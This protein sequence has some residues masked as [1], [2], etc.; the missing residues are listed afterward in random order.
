PAALRHPAGPALTA[1]NG[2]HGPNTDMAAMTDRLAQRL[3]QNGNNR[4]GWLLLARSYHALGRLQDSVAAYDKAVALGPDN[5]DLLIEY[6]NTLSIAQGRDLSGKPWRLIRQALKIEPDN[7]NALALA[8]AAAVQAGRPDDA[9]R[10]WTH[11]KR[12]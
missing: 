11:L 5:A 7:L 9:V 6:A 12:L 10:Y 2:P 8:G 4:E 3:E 1:A